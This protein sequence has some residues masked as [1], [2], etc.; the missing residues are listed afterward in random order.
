[1]PAPTALK[2]ADDAPPVAQNDIAIPE[3]LATRCYMHRS[4]ANRPLP[5]DL[6]NGDEEFTLETTDNID[7]D[8]ILAPVKDNNDSMMVDEEGRPRFAAARD[9]VRQSYSSSILPAY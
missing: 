4:T 1:M 3:G 2:K 6:E 8:T 7:P 5:M 9:I